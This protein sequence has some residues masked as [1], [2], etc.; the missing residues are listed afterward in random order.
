[1]TTMSLVCA[2]YRCT[3]NKIYTVCTY[4][5]KK[6]RYVLYRTSAAMCRCCCLYGGRWIRGWWDG[7]RVLCVWWFEL[8][9]GRPRVAQNV[10][11]ICGH[12]NVV[13]R[14]A[15]D[16]FHW[17][18]QQQLDQTHRVRMLMAAAVVAGGILGGVVRI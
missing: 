7:G 16:G 18:Q 10:H 13:R 6:C 1:M 14:V 3:A 2:A 5:T 8:A 11:F 17:R 9:D 15:Y 4:T 12:D